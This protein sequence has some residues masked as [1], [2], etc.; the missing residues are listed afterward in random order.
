MTPS[1]RF[2][3]RRVRTLL[4][5]AAL[6][7]I[8][9]GSWSVMADSPQQ[10]P[11]VV[12]VRAGRLLDVRQGQLREKM[13]ILI[14]GEKIE[15]VGSADSTKIPAGAEVIDLSAFTVLPGLIDAHV[16]LAWGTPPLDQPNA[17]VGAKEATT[18]LHAGFTT[19]RNPGSTSHADLLLRDAINAGRVA[20]P[21]IVAAGP[22]LG[23]KGGVCDQVFQGEGAANGADEVRRKAAEIIS[24]GADFIKLCAGG[25]VIPSAR[26]QQTVEYAEDEIR[27]IVE[28]A[29]RQGRKVAAHAQG[30]EAILRAVRAGVDSIEHGAWI[31][32]EAAGLMKERNVYLVPTLYRISWALENAERNGAPAANLERFR[33]NRDAMES[34]V[35]RA[36]QLG[37]PIAFGTDATVYPHGLNAREFAVYVRLGMTPLDAIRSATVNA[38]DLLGWADRVGTVEPGRFADLIAV[39]GNPLEDVR[40]LESVRFVMK[41]GAIFRS[42]NK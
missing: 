30:P 11:A 24:A 28:E 38:A 18:T 31:N 12:A 8:A 34:N 41:S 32:E 1:T 29:H 35:R 7:A 20:G 6:V 14:R 26:D 40:V 3:F 4:I 15:A 2:A 21:R 39:S 16:H 10:K 23:S 19:V 22:A 25:A 9:A 33:G 5:S 42:H 37:V 36:I 27:V 13:I 17:I